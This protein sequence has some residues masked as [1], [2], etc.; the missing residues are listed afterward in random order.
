MIARLFKQLL[1]GVSAAPASKHTTDLAA[2]TLLVE[3]MRAD[4]SIDAQERR[5]LTDVL[6]RLFSSLTPEE[7]SD[8]VHEAE[9]TSANANDLYQFT[10][11]VHQHFS[12]EQKFDLIAG[13]W[14]VAWASNG[15]DRYEEHIIRRISELLYIPHSEFIRAKLKA[16]P[17]S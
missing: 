2:A 15:L 9:T 12:V 6:G 17:A 8:L 7:L 1:D 13:L 10:E 14:E 11:L 4:L 16:R 5:A 3:V